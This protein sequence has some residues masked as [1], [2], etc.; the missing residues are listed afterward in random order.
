VSYDLIP[1]TWARLLYGAVFLIVLALLFIDVVGIS[2][3]SI[4]NSA[5]ALIVILAILPLLGRIKSARFGTE[6]VSVEMFEQVQEE[7]RAVEDL[8]KRNAVGV[9]RARELEGMLL[10]SDDDIDSSEW[11]GSAVAPPTLDAGEGR[12]SEVAAPSGDRPIL[13]IER[14]VWVDDNPE[15]NAPYRDELERRWEVVTATSTRAGMALIT[16][17]P[18]RTLVIT[19]AVRDEGGQKNYEAGLDLIAWLREE[20]PD[21]PVLVFAGVATVQEYG[22]VFRAAHAS[23]VTADFGALFNA[24]GAIDRRRLMAAIVAKLQQAGLTLVAQPPAVDLLARRS[25]GR[26]I[27]IEVK[28]WQRTPPL[29]LVESAVARLATAQRKAGAEEALLIVRTGLPQGSFGGLTTVPSDLH[30]VPFDQL[31]RWLRD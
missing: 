18:S 12:R 26:R 31:E 2:D 17:D 16:A 6:G 5:I 7:L 10:D 30:I 21:V 20:H 22:D 4:D 27:A 25:D 13:P 24:I 9:A 14:I 15:G 23:A 28:T 11:A 8:T 1:A 19:D 3:W 29:Q